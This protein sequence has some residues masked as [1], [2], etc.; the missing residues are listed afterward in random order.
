MDSLSVL[1]FIS[2]VY[3]EIW[4]QIPG[5]YRKAVEEGLVFKATTFG[6]CE[7]DEIFSF[8]LIFVG[9]IIYTLIAKVLQCL[10]LK[11]AIVFLFLS[12][13]I[14]IRTHCQQQ[15]KKR[16]NLTVQFMQY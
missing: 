4:A 15:Q 2:R 7:L 9:L 13:F 6:L 11:Y 3:D 8:C 12:W 5:D 1:L 10:S 16:I 14:E